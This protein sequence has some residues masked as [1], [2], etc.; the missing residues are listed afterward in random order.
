MS[1]DSPRPRRSF[2]EELKRGEP[3][4]TQ[5][6]GGRGGG[7]LGRVGHGSHGEHGCGAGDPVGCVPRAHHQPGRRAIRFG[8]RIRVARP[9][10]GPQNTP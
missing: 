2:S 6:H 3:F 7:L 1:A 8:V 9:L 4:K 5:R 10:I